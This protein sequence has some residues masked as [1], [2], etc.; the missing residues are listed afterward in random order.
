MGDAYGLSGR[1]ARYRADHTVVVTSKLIQPE[2][3]EYFGQI[4]PETTVAYVE[5]LA[6]LGA[7]LNQLALT[8]RSGRCRVVLGRFQSLTFGVDLASLL[9]GRLG[10]A[11]QIE[12]AEPQLGLG[13]V[14]AGLPED[15]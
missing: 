6:N 3:R 2:V 8:I 12:R 14:L 4:K 5:G 1:L 7:A 15:D 13:S 9:S 11:R 10:L